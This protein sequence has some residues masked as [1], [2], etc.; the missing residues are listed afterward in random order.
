MK[1]LNEKVIRYGNHSIINDN[2]G[3]MYSYNSSMVSSFDTHMHKC[4]EIIHI[5]KGEL[6]YTV[7][8]STYM[9]SDGDIIFTAPPERHS[10]RFIKKCQ[11]EREFL[12]IYPGFIKKFPELTKI[13]SFRKAGTLN[14]IDVERVNK[15]ELDQIFN[16]INYY[17]SMDAPEKDLMVLTYTIQL[18]II[19]NRILT[20][21]T[22][23]YSN[24]SI[25]SKTDFI[26][27]YIDHHY[28]EE[29]SAAD[30]AEK[31]FT[32]QQYINKILKEKMG[33]TIKQYL[34][35]R[36]ISAAKNLIMEGH[37]TTN[38]YI[39]CGFRDYSTFYRA[40]AKYAGMTP[41][42]FKKSQSGR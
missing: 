27:D 37:K 29:I 10:F 28:K 20:D 18:L 12:H 15:Y 19:M 40:F 42:K 11:Y 3:Y 31:T 22:P 23:T 6:L 5:I 13:L 1:I 7:E 21:D 16:K 35:L 30:I 33:M 8:D 34:N 32:S 25:D 39:Q 41:D 9:L 2:E 14:R 4:Y 38:I 36:R 24:I 17:G 26:I